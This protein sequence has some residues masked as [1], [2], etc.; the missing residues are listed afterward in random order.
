MRILIDTREQAP[1]DFLRCGADIET[2]RAALPIGDYSL[3]GLQDRVAV[4]RKSLPDLTRC[5][6]AERERFERELLRAAALD[7]FC[8]VVEAPWQALAD[9]KYRSR[10][11]PGAA[12][13]SVGAFMA[14][15]RIPFFFAG[16]RTQAEAFTALYL[17]QWLKG[18]VH[19]LDAMRAALE[20]NAGLNRRC[21]AKWK[22]V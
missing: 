9:G 5:L 3:A 18:K 8:V 12:C 11:N 6:G 1:F 7:S 21:R 2:E 10:L 14:R 16:S 22:E 13:A 17:R 4:E 15:H 20:V 19:D